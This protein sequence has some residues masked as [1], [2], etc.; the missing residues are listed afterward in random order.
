[1]RVLQSLVVSGLWQQSGCNTRPLGRCQYQQELGTR[2]SDS[3][4][5]AR[6]CVKLGLVPG[7]KRCVLLV[8]CWWGWHDFRISRVVK[9]GHPYV[10]DLFVPACCTPGGQ[11]NNAGIIAI[12]KGGMQI[13]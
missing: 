6:T 5:S 12:L 2:Y 9:R 8:D 1:M 3:I 7:T 13:Q 11:P 4:L 10:L